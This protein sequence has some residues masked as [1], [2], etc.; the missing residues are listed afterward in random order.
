MLRAIPE[1]SHHRARSAS[2]PWGD[3]P[4]ASCSGHLPFVAAS[5]GSSQAMLFSQVLW[6]QRINRLIRSKVAG[7]A[8]T[9]ALAG[10]FHVIG[11]TRTC[12]HTGTIPSIGSRLPAGWRSSMAAKRMAESDSSLALVWES[13]SPMDLKSWRRSSMPYTEPSWQSMTRLALATGFIMSALVPILHPLPHN[14]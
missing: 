1:R 2:K 9:Q 11:L 8:F 13:A 7:S 3:R 10:V 12:T 5:D 14:R 6:R 4:I